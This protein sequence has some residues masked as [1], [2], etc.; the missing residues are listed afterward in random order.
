M[1]PKYLK[2]SN[3]LDNYLKSVEAQKKVKIIDIDWDV[4]E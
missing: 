4:K 3:Q 1:L 2:D